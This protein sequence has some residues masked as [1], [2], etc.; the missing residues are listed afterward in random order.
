MLCDG[1]GLELF[2]PEFESKG[3]G[4]CG[5]EHITL[6]LCFFFYKIETVAP[7]LYQLSELNE[8]AHVGQPSLSP[9]GSWEIWQPWP[10]QFSWGCS[11]E[12]WQLLIWQSLIWDLLPP[13]ALAS[14]SSLA[15]PVLLR[16]EVGNP[17]EVDLR[18]FFLCFKGVNMEAMSENKVVSSEFS[19]GPVE[20]AAKPLPFKDPN[21]VVSI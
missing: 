3:Q 19:T 9:R 2:W 17:E 18:F 20:K 1:H 16:A 15:C 13:G 8:R 21:F 4:L 7:P 5:L 10:C 14:L 12:Q 6:S 11:A